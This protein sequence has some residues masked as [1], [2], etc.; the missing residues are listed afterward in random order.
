MIGIAAKFAALDIL[1]D[2]LS[3]SGDAKLKVLGE[4]L[5]KHREFGYFGALGPSYGDFSP[6]RIKADTI[7]SPGAN[8][9]VQIWKTIFGVFG[10]DGT[11]GNPG[12]KPVL[13]KIRNLL[14]KLDQ[15][16]ANEDLSA[17]QGLQ[18]EVATLNQIAADLNAIVITIKG[19]GT[20][21]N[22][23]IV[24]QF[25]TLIG[26]TS[27]PAI[28]K[29]R[30]DGKVGFPSRFW[31]LRDFL[32]WRRT[33]R[34]AKRL[35]DS[36]Q[37][38]GNDDLRAYALG[39]LSTWSL[40]ASGASAVASIIGAPYRNQWW[41]ARFVSNYSDVW[42]W[43]HGTVGPDSAPYNSWPNLCDQDL[44]KRI[45][46]PGVTLDAV[47]VMEKLRLATALT[48]ALP[49]AFVSFWMGAYDDVYGDLGP[50]R[51]Q[52]TADTLQDAYGLAW[53]VLWFQTSPESLGCHHTMPA[54]PTDCG[55][56]PSWTNP[57]VPGDNG[58][59]V[60]PPAPS[61]DP[62]VKP[63]NVVCAIILAILGIIAFALGGGLVGA[64]LIAGAIALAA[65]AGTIDWAKFRCD[66]AWYRLYMY[67]GLRA[68]HDLL[69][70]GA[71]AHPYKFE[72]S[73]ETT[74]VNLLQDIP[75]EFKTGDHILKSR[76]TGKER[77]P[78]IPWSGGGFSWFNDV[79]DPLEDVATE[80]A[81][82]SAYPS[83]FLDD[84]AN[85]LGSR[86]PFD[87]PVAF[88]FDADG[89]NRPFG[90]INSTEAMLGWLN[91][92]GSTLPD[93]NLDG[94]RGL[95]FRTWHFVDDEWTDP[96]NIEPEV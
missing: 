41:R 5:A 54:A 38:S 63:L 45:Q 31:T 70:L 20:L 48:T 73:Q 84:P 14:D 69:S 9:Y 81:R 80:P 46:F 67:N 51:P 77:F 39:W 72:L 87:Q 24:P 90:F 3:A 8:P 88:P 13:D 68:L 33:G 34:F 53:L 19:D 82:A 17:L 62:K 93:L 79:T 59:G 16:A 10:G 52:V 23:G 36:A 29:P 66:L 89:A 11:A 21:N 96:V 91:G 26:D 61:V 71:L 4:L 76:A 55:S 74:S 75:T 47:D 57:A 42:S 1:R 12:L 95:G 43:G 64:G 49:G 92:P 94:D 78:A 25:A 7:G 60:G 83:G 6:V 18:G 35:W 15:I 65:T 30:P 37:A 44:H 50:D 2:R 27:R 32:S 86:S 56:A 22:L 85:P 40:S 58:T 28:I